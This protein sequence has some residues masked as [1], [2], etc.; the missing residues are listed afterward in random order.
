MTYPQRLTSNSSSADDTAAVD[1]T[2]VDALSFW[3]EQVESSR[4]QS[5]SA[6]VALSERFSGIVRRLDA[7]LGRDN[8]SAGLRNVADDARLGE[9]DL[10]RVIEALRAISATRNALADEIRGLSSYLEELRRMAADVESIAFKTNMLSLN[11]AIEAAHAGDAGKG[12]AVVAHEV[13]SLSGAARETGKN[14]TQ[15]IALI[16]ETLVRIGAS[17]EQVQLRDQKQIE[18]SESHIKAVLARFT[19]HS[20]QLAELARRSHAESAAIKDE[21]SE[22]L[23]QLQ[24][25]DRV[26]QILS[27]VVGSMSELRAKAAECSSDAELRQLIERH[28]EQVR[29]SCSHKGLAKRPAAADDVTYF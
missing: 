2:L 27:Q 22:S 17:N 21:I 5:E 6:I 13:R 18:G 7:A 8:D 16:R 14:I 12:F 25:Q 24:F 23:M 1:H 19:Q 11:A 20:S 29:R 26:S 15:K 4:L 9:Q 10:Q 3:A 28:V